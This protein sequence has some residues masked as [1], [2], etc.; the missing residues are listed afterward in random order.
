LFFS[1]EADEVEMSFPP[2]DDTT[3]W[4]TAPADDIDEGDIVGVAIK[5]EKVLR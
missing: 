1:T 3:A 2:F 5:K 4:G